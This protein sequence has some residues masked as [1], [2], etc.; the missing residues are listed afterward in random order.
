MR[1][2]RSLAVPGVSVALLVIALG[3]AALSVNTLYLRQDPGA[4]RVLVAAVVAI[5]A[6][7]AGRTRWIAL[8]AALWFGWSAAS[9][10]WSV[11]PG[12][13]VRAVW[14]ELAYLAAF[15]IGLRYPRWFLWGFGAF[16]LA[17][18]AH[19]VDNLLVTQTSHFVGIWF[20]KNVQGAQLLLV[21]PLLAAGAARRERWAPY[22]G[23]PLGFV[24]FLASL[25][26]AAASQFLLAA[27]L[28]VFIVVA[29][30]S[31]RGLPRGQRWALALLI[32]A[33]AG[34]GWQTVQPTS[35]QIFTIGVGNEQL[36]RT[37][38]AIGNSLHGRVVMAGD[39]LR[40][41]LPRMPLGIGAGSIRDT[42]SAFQTNPKIESVDLHDYYVQ[43]LVT[44]GPLGLALWVALV[45]ASLV[46]AIR[47]RMWGVAAAVF[48]FSGYLAFD[49]PAYFPSLMAMYV[50]LLGVAN[51]RRN[52]GAAQGMPR[53]LTV[54]IAC[55]VML[56][57][58]GYVVWSLPCH[59]QQCVIQRRL[60]DR[61][62]VDR[63]ASTQSAADNVLLYRAATKANPYAYWAQAGLARALEGSEAWTQALDVRRAM[64]TEFPNAN[65][66]VYLR[67]YAVAKRLGDGQQADEAIAASKMHFPKSPLSGCSSDACKVGELARGAG[68]GG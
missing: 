4:F 6:L 15:L 28:L 5:V 24:V 57:G 33:G 22:L 66:D 30:R 64:A 36:T 47:A 21:A 37:T 55:T 42:F 50:G 26:R 58:V 49:V 39:A 31:R 13:T 67:W 25:T 38:D 7:L 27:M 19:G 44:T 12:G 14:W 56:V 61:T 20:E 29:F 34:A 10:V 54:G 9:V 8:G 62:S 68:P 45:V 17:T 11:D 1:L 53:W 2:T 40:F 41:A 3:T 43:S 16:S 65:A 51:A 18:L 23:F 63:L 60:A 48:L 52:Q 59:D 46:A 35:A 32:L